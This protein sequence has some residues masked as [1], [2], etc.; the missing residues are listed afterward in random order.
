MKTMKNSIISGAI[1]ASLTLISSSALA[2]DKDTVLGT[3]NGEEVTQGQVMTF[4][5]TQGPS[6]GV[7]PQ[8]PNAQ[9][10]FLKLFLEREALYHEATALN[11]AKHSQEQ[12]EE[13]RRQKLAQLVVEEYISKNKPTEKQIE[14]FYQ[15]EVVAN[16]KEFKLRHIQ[17]QSP[18]QAKAIYER[19]NNGDD[20]ATVANEISDQ[21]AKSGGDLGWLSISA[22]PPSFSMAARSLKA[23]EYSPQPVQSDRGL[24]IIKVEESRA[25]TPPPLDQVRQKIS[26]AITTQMM[27]AYI[28]EIKDKYKVEPID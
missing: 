10:Q 12:L 16:S 5:V 15:K 9:A 27:T 2:V 8:N 26:E 20:F 17:L 23:G 24:H 18:N 19:L 14:D 1:A 25:I 4:I 6:S 3:I 11:I 21:T 22:M 13:A 28:S 7:N